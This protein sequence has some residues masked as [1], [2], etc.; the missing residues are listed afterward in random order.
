MQLHQAYKFQ[1]LSHANVCNHFVMGLWVF[2][3]GIHK[4][5]TTYVKI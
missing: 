3:Q 5:L 1:A 4:D 2:T